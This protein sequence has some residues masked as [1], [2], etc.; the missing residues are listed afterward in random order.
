M[1]AS[2][3]TTSAPQA[4]AGAAVFETDIPSRLDRLPWCRFHWLVIVALG[5]TW[6][7]DGLE[8]TLVGSLAGAI[9]DRSS[10]G[11][12]ETEIGLSASAYLAGA[13]AGAILFG[14]LTDRLGRKPLFFVTVA[15]YALATM[16]TGLSWN[17]PS[18]A[19]FRFLTGAGIGGE[20]TAINSAI[21]EL[22][23][24]RYRGWTDLTVNGS[25][26]VGAALGALASLVALDPA[27]VPPGLG[28]RVAFLL[29]GLLGFGVMTLRRYVPES[30]RWLMTHG[31]GEEAEASLREI[32]GRIAADAVALPPPSETTRVRLRAIGRVG[33]VALARTVITA[34]PRRAILGLALMSAQAFF[35]NAIFFTY[36]LVLNRFYGVPN[37]AIGRYILAFALGN[38]MG[39]LLLG[40]LF[41][42]LG[43]KTMIAGTYALSGLLMTATAVLFKAGML[44][45]VSQTAAWTG[46][47]FVASAA[48]SSAYLTVSESFP[49]EL[50]ALIIALFYAL[51]TAIGGLAGPALFGALIA[52]GSR[53]EIMWG[54]LGGAALMRRGGAALP[55]SRGAAALERGLSGRK[56][57]IVRGAFRLFQYLG[58]DGTRPRPGTAASSESGGGSSW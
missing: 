27:I 34:Y 41:D 37:A 53:G 6:V 49:L 42:T 47:F 9:A 1:T 57:G 2:S 14:Y 36:A 55:R 31:R 17:F 26:W 33:F 28:W 52:S 13:I 22:I 58:R 15:V 21:Q 38:F 20:Y 39:P 32:E 48:A 18:F 46:I 23:P 24:A 3:P 29:G 7:L 44:D 25:F 45:A 43:R 11:L 40:R 4:V 56:A 5:I 54:Y 35:Y 10:L 12:S 50:R 16:A 51:G 30:P 8:V 19:L